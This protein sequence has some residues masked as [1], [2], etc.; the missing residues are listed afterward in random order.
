MHRSVLVPVC[1]CHYVRRDR[2]GIVRDCEQHGKCLDR[3]QLEF[4]T[5]VHTLIFFNCVYYC[6][7]CSFT[8]LGVFSDIVP[9]TFAWSNATQIFFRKILYLVSLIVSFQP[10]G[11]YEY[12]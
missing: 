5:A 1:V 9:V 8:G 11:A 7:Y 6:Y 3:L 10:V 2:P 12:F 4:M